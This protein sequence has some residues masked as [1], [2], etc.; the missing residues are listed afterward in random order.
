MIFVPVLSPSGSVL[1]ALWY[2]PTLEVTFPTVNTIDAFELA[3][4][5]VIRHIPFVLVVQLAEAPFGHV[6]RTTAPETGVPAWFTTRTRTAAR[7]PADV[8][9][10]RSSRSPM[11]TL[12][13][14]LDGGGDELGEGDGVGEVL[15][16]EELGE[17][18]GE[19]LVDGEL[20]ALGDVDVLGEVVADGDV[21][22]EAD[23]DALGEELGDDEGDEEGLGD[24]LDPTGP[25]NRSIAYEPPVPENRW[26]SSVYVPAIVGVHSIVSCRPETQLSPEGQVLCVTSVFVGS[27]RATSRSGS[28]PQLRQPKGGP[29]SS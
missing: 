9:T 29:R 8:R 17:G 12:G 24:A 21:V 18:D 19:V 22:G 7:Q 27:H 3:R 13:D 16:D 26:T 1:S 20:E 25:V 14:V 28:M 2:G 11:W 5:R 6:P 10:L 23:G 15:D 4:F